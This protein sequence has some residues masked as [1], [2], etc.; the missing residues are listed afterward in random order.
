MKNARLLMANVKDW[1][2]RPCNYA[3]GVKVYSDKEATIMGWLT[4]EEV[5]RLEIRD[6]GKGECYAT[7]RRKNVESS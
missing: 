6:F 4:R 5:E 7:V 2:L 3:L 1:D